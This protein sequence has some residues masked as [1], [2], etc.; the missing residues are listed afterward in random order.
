MGES[1]EA[2]ERKLHHQLEK[3]EKREA[4]EAKQSLEKLADKHSMVS[5]VRGLGLLL[6]MELS[7]PAAPYV[8]ALMNRGFLV[9]VVAERTL[10][11]TPPLNVT[12][13]EV[14]SVLSALDE[15]LTESAG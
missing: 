10:R 11:F 12:E 1:A 15:I 2:D 3:D 8:Q 9:T 6:G 4:L 13:I 7:E 14:D 5:G